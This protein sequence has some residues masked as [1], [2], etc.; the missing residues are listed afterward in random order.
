MVCTNPNSGFRRSNGTF[1][2]TRPTAGASIEMVLPCGVCPGCKLDRAADLQTV[3]ICEGLSHP[4]SLMVN[5]TYDDANLPPDMSVNRVD[6]VSFIKRLRAWVDYTFKG[7]KI[8]YFVAAEYG[9]NTKRPHY[10]FIIFGLSLQD[11]PDVQF[12]KKSGNYCLYK[13]EKLNALWGKGFV[14]FGVAVPGGMGYTAGYLTK[15]IGSSPDDIRYR[16][17]NILTGET[18]QV[19]P[20]F[21]SRSAGL[22]RDFIRKH[23]DDLRSG[24]LVFEGQRR[25]IPPYF[26]K[27]L[28]GSFATVG[29]EKNDD[30][31]IDDLDLATAKAREFAQSDSAQANNTPERLRVREESLLIRTA[32][33]NRD[34]VSHDE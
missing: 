22:G 4:C 17:T 26:R 14:N 12:Y 8:R 33:S 31:V 30:F 28:R 10:H 1:S 19:M 34:K 21:H 24:Y 2:K 18:W 23:R 5:V 7:R 27:F 11:F 9:S 25:R 16:R 13:S 15:K 32:A 29:S 6:P 20:E 3:M